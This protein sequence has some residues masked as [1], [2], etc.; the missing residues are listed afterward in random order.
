[1]TTH[2]VDLPDVTDLDVVDAKQVIR[3]RIRDRRSKMTAAQIESYGEDFAQMVAQFASNTTTVAMYASVNSEPSTWKALQLLHENDYGILLPKLGPGLARMWAW[4]EGEDRLV[5][6]APG[7]PLSP[8]S[9]PLNSDAIEQVGA[10]IIPALAVDRSGH[11]IGQGGGWY[12][13]MLKLDVSGADIGAMIYPWELVD[14]DLPYDEMDR[15]AEWAILPDQLI[16][17]ED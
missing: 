11:R 1:M 15:T 2:K 7:R 6:D 10:I 5:T 4:Y 16:K 9:E 17:L 3:S 12:D 13:R 8:D 14:I